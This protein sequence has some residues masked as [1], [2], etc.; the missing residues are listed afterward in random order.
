MSVKNAQDAFEKLFDDAKKK[1]ENKF[2]AGLSRGKQGLFLTSIT[3]GG[4]NTVESCIQGINDALDDFDT[5]QVGPSKPWRRLNTKKVWAKLIKDI[6]ADV[7]STKNF[8]AI[9]GI[10]EYSVLRNWKLDKAPRGYFFDAGKSIRN[11]GG[12]NAITLLTFHYIM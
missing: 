8:G 11:I 6:L 4:Q 9:Q 7:K 1:F 12:V 3:F 2:T 5:K 10:Q